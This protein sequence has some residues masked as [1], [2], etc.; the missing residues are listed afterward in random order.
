MLPGVYKI[1]EE[2]WVVDVAVNEGIGESGGNGGKNWNG[3]IKD[4]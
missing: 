1:R 2:G 4:G 3:G